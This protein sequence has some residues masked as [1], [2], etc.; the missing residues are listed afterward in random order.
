MQDT[1]RQTRSL[2][3]VACTI[4]LCAC[5]GSAITPAAQ[6]PELPDAW[7][8]GG[9]DG[10]TEF[11]WLRVFGDADLS[12]LVSDAIS[13]NFDLEQERARLAQAKQ[14]VI[15]SGANR[16]PSLDVSLSGSR[17][18]SEDTSGTSTITESF[19]GG[20]DARWE[21]DLW[22]RLSKLQQSARLNFA[23]QQSRLAGAE[24][25]L[26]I[27]TVGTVF[28][29]M[30]ARQL[31]AVAERRLEN[32]LQSHDIVES[33]YS[34]G[35][36]EALDL[37]L[38]RNQVKRQE[39]N[40]ASQRQSLTETI[41][42]LQLTLAHYPDGN[43]QLDGE[44]PDVT[45]DVPVGLPSELLTRRT[46]LQE[47]WLNL[48]AAD[49]WLAAAHKARFPSLSLVAGSDVSSGEFSD[50]LDGSSSW[51][52]LTNLSQPLFAGGRL[53]AAEKHA[54]ERVRES[55]QRYLGLIQLAFSEVENAISNSVSLRTRYESLRDAEVNARAALNLA[56][57]QFQLGL[58]AY[59]TV[60]ESQRQAFD[61]EA[62]VVQLKNQLLQNRL[63]LY[64]ALGGEFTVTQ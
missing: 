29:V 33:G 5:A 25:D 57:E 4:C 32:A 52:V 37:Y 48:L 17:R 28:R 23:A 22:G 18:G 15:I 19:D 24:R 54:A 12:A 36:N 61:A 44:L 8:R 45:V 53:A 20:L 43:M 7:A 35:L 1:V 50:L 26:A 10:A 14:T 38:A 21:I 49:A 55:E 41:A 39:A 30:E 62:T 63:S 40:V 47:A 34:Q 31:L 56:L 11:D 46:D 42:E 51:S 13:S 60:L 59:T 3:L 9:A 2:V 6:D 64:L 16:Y 27:R 58:V